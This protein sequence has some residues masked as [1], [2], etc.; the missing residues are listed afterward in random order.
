M[1]TVASPLFVTFSDPIT[2][3]TLT[4]AALS[5][6]DNNV[7][8]P[9]PA[10]PALVVTQTGP[11]TYQITGLD[12]ETAPLGNY[13]LTVDAGAVDDA[14]GFA[15]TGTATASWT[16]T[17]LT[18]TATA[19]TPSTASVSFGQSATFT[20]TVSSA[21]GT[22]PDGSV[23]FLVN[24]A[25]YG[26]AVP[27]SGATAQLQSPSPRAATRSR[28]STPATPTMP[29]PCRPRRPAPHSWSVKR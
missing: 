20:A 19:V 17:T 14:N 3:G 16:T 1:G 22:P 24:G 13:V 23:Q 15:G 6:T 4:S 11:A 8:V 25:S 7:N 27:L 10:S 21:S 5:L 18:A 28:R 29:R 9:I 12:S 26:S 2:L